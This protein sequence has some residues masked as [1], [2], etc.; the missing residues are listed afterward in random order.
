[1]PQKSIDTGINIGISSCLLGHPV[2]YDGRHNYCASMIDQLRQHFRCIP[3]CPEVEIGLGVP[4]APIKL[5]RGKCNQ[6]Q[7]INDDNQDLSTALRYYADYIQQ[8]HPDLG[9][10]VFKSRSPSCGKNSVSLLNKNDQ[11]ITKTSGVYCRRLSDLYEEMPMVED[12]DLITKDQI[13][14]F[15]TQV[16]RYS[17]QKH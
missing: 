13:K 1:M 9:G 4:R 11:E 10:Y 8:L 7:A 17:Q 12:I 14:Q 3:I 16:K 2:R 6:I 5:Y 15:I